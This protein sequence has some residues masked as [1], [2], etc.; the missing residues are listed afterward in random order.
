MVE[1]P[2]TLILGAGASMDYGF[3]SGQQLL[4]NIR[5]L[6]P[7]Q[8]GQL[9]D[10]IQGLWELMPDEAEQTVA[11]FIESLKRADPPSIHDYLMQRLSTNNAQRTVNLARLAIAQQMLVHQQN[12]DLYPDRSWYR[13]LLEKLT[14]GNFVPRKNRLSVITFNYDLS[15]EQYLFD[16]FRSRYDLSDE[17]ARGYVSWIPIV[18]IFGSLGPLP[19]QAPD[20]RETLPYRNR[21][22]DQAIARAAQGISVL[23]GSD[24]EK[25]EHVRNALSLIT[26]SKLVLFFGFAYHDF[27]MKLLL[28][29]FSVQKIVRGTSYGLTATER[30]A[31]GIKYKNIFHLEV[32]REGRD[33]VEFMQQSAV[34]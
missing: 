14:E 15:L 12:S 22:S 7:D 23:A 10:I 11:E 25:A 27:G 19:W 4:R 28:P 2:T 9:S 20:V 13:L 26:Q 24:L 34:V 31:L 5:S 6:S 33:I 30:T 29:A 21:A 3:P 16:A 17:T 8:R 18:H 32:D 1:T